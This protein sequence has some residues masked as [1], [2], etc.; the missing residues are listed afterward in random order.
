MQFHWRGEKKVALSYT[1]NM[2]QMAVMG[3]SSAFAPNR[4]R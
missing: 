4:L 3:A 2:A 1:A